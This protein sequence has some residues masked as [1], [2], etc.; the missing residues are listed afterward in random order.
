MLDW[1]NNFGIKRICRI[2]LLKN[3]RVEKFCLPLLPLRPRTLRG[4]PPVDLYVP[5]GDHLLLNVGC[6]MEQLCHGSS[7]PVFGDPSD[8]DPQQAG[9]EISRDL[10]L[11]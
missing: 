11:E 6:P 1:K 3:Q 8:A 4:M 10:L 9:Q 5:G 2:D 7:I